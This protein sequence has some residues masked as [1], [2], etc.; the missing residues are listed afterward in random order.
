M[1]SS[2]EQDSWLYIWYGAYKLKKELAFEKWHRTWKLPRVYQSL[3][4]NSKVKVVVVVCIYLLL[5]IYIYIYSIYYYCLLNY[6]Y[7]VLLYAVFHQS[8]SSRTGGQSH[9]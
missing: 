3:E 6:V 4:I 7:C 9:L 5:Y 8:G 1:R 2:N